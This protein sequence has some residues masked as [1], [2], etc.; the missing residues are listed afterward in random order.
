MLAKLRSDVVAGMA[1]APVQVNGPEIAEWD[2]TGKTANLD[3][4]AATISPDLGVILEGGDGTVLP[5]RP[6][7]RQ[8]LTPGQKVALGVRPEHFHPVGDRRA[9][10]RGGQSGLMTVKVT[11]V[12]PVGSE[13]I[14]V[15]RLT[16]GGEDRW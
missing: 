6:V 12:E 5:L 1:P 8:G 7:Q 10:C 4:L 3:D 14:L 9:E 15:A 16:R 13:T 11:L 2:A